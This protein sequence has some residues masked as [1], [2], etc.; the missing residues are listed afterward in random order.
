MNA[1]QLE[2]CA[3]EALAVTRGLGDRVNVAGFSLGGLLTAH[4]AQR[5]PIRRAVAV[6]PFLGIGLI[7]SVF[8]L[9]LA[10]WALSRPNKF[11]WWDPVLREKQMPEHGYPQFAT[12]AVAH[13][14]TLAHQVLEAAKNDAPAAH[15]IVL[16]LNP[17]DSTVN[18]RAIL[19]LWSRWSA[20]KPQSVT[21]HRLT[22]LPP[23]LHDIIEP[24][25]YPEVSQRVTREVV[26]LI[27]Q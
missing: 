27:A 5:E 6:S 3:S 11:Y 23:F 15:D 22:G 18:K 1:A 13:G 17:R 2:A 9:P 24:K 4:L 26:E 8:R 12:H 10:R 7:P 20:L 25:R 16:V 19:R 14:L 21:L